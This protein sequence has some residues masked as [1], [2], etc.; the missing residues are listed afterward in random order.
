MDNGLLITV[1]GAAR[2]CWISE[3]TAPRRVTIVLRR[4]ILGLAE[5]A[6]MRAKAMCADMPDQPRRRIER[7]LAQHAPIWA[8]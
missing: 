8:Q 3:F 4:G 7:A 2:V 6:T 1:K 5:P